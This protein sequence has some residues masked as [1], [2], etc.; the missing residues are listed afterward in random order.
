MPIHIDI[1]PINRLV[2][3]V[4]HGKVTPDEIV[5]VRRQLAAAKVPDYAKMVD[6]TA[7]S[8]TITREQIAGITAMRGTTASSAARWPSWSTPAGL[9]SPRPSPR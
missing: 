7:P 1:S 9:T 3:I 8:T 6:T 2:V 5:D 4:A